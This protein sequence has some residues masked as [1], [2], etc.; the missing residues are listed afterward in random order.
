MS[1]TRVTQGHKVIVAAGGQA[2]ARVTQ[3]H[4]IVIAAGGTAP[5]MVG[6]AHKVIIFCPNTP[7]P[8]PATPP[9]QNFMSSVP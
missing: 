8:D 7:E 9:G 5:A 4:K 6:Q 3:G 2:P 1:N